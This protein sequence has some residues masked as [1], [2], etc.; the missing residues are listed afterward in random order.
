MRHPAKT[1]TERAAQELRRAH[2]ERIGGARYGAAAVEC[3]VQPHEQAAAELLALSGGPD[4]GPGGEVIRTC[5]L[6]E[7]FV[8]SLQARNQGT[9]AVVRNTLAEGASRVAEDASVRRTDLLMQSSFDAL[10]MGIDAA[11]SIGA[12]NSLEK[13]LAHQM[14]IAHEAIMRMTDRA[15]SYEHNTS[16]DQTEACR[17]A[18]TAAR[19]MGAFQGG[20][21]TLQRLRTGGNQTVTVQH[22]NVQPGGQAVIGNPM[23]LWNAPRCGAHARTTGNPCRGPAMPNGRCR[24]H[25]GKAGRKPTHGRYTKGAIAQRR[26]ARMILRTLR[27]LLR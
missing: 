12:E 19:L 8:P 24:M 16:G 23:Q 10:A 22:V 4:V 7:G 6:P 21:L 3:F 13:M 14:A 1:A 17:C 5:S 26:R 2:E 25:G 18:N 9:R 11:D 15:M 20:M 27:A